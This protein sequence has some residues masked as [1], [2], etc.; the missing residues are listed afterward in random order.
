MHEREP[1]AERERTTLED[2]E[3]EVAPD[4]AAKVTGGGAVSAPT[5]SPT[6]RLSPS[7]L[8]PPDTINPPD[9]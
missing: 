5:T 7:L 4:E 6:R 8:D 2:L 9:T 1:E 3:V